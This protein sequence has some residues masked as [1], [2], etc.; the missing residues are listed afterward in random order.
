MSEFIKKYNV[1]TALLIFIALP[2]IFLALGDFPRRTV[3]KES[4]S[5][6]TILA[7]FLMLAQFFLTRSSKSILKVHKMSRILTMHK[8]MGYIVVLILLIHPFLIVVPRYF[9]S[10]IAPMDACMTLVTSFDSLGVVLGMIAWCLML[11]LGL[12]SMLRNKLGMPYKTWRVFHG[13]LSILFIS[14]ATW[15]AIDL[16]R[17]MD[18]A[19]SI[20]MIILAGSGIMLLL[21]TYFFK[22][23]KK[24]GEKVNA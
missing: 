8:L 6:L 5:I 18:K 4:I 24:V 3:L 20:F 9:E 2:L 23:A 1:T 10:G 22:S 15:H 19:M 11:I 14:L 17:H 16:G 12:T 21:N 13:I 7:F